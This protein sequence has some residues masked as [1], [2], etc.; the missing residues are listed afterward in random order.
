MQNLQ[1]Y[2]KPISTLCKYFYF[3]LIILF[4]EIAVANNEVW[5]DISSYLNGAMS[6]IAIH[7]FLYK[8]R[9]GIKE[10]LGLISKNV[11]STLPAALSKPIVSFRIWLV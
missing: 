7:T 1:V 4:I 3:I 10:K 2:F 6:T 9:H 8:G 11:V 5:T